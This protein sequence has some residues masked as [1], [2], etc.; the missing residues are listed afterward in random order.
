ME[1]YD[2]PRE[3]VMLR[4]R[5]DQRRQSESTAWICASQRIP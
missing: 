4:R 3:A 1:G 2:T 5:Q